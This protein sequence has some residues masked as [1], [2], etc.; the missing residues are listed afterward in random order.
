MRIAISQSPPPGPNTEAEYSNVDSSTKPRGELALLVLLGYKMSPNL[1]ITLHYKDI[2]VV[3]CTCILNYG[4][5]HYHETWLLC[6]VVIEKCT[7]GLE[8]EKS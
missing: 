8:E 7:E 5:V 4:G 2:H 1:V 3:Y 6:T